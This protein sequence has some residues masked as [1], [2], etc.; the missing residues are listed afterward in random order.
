FEDIHLPIRHIGT[1]LVFGSLMYHNLSQLSIYI[2]TWLSRAWNFTRPLTAFGP[3]NMWLFTSHVSRYTSRS[4]NVKNK[5]SFV[6][7]LNGKTMFRT[8]KLANEL[9]S[10]PVPKF[11]LVM[12]ELNMLLLANGL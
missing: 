9:I 5:V 8:S 3:G 12:F 7:S 11:S 6:S 10:L 4:S 2:Y 1:M